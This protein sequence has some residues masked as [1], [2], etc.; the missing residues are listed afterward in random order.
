MTEI[1][2]WGRWAAGTY[3]IVLGLDAL[4]ASMAHVPGLTRE[5]SPE[6]AYSF[7]LAHALLIW[8]P[9]FLCAWG[10]FRWRAWARK[11][12]LALSAFFAVAGFG[13]W[14]YFRMSGRLDTPLLVGALLAA[15][16]LVWLVSPPVRAE[17]WRRNQIE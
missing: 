6:A 5:H 1:V 11:T 15:A 4:F 2:N 16:V 17:Y 7:V 10:V 12:G 13:I 9:A 14:I 8:L 3:F